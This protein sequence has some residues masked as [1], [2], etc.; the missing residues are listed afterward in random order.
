MSD[1]DYIEY[2]RRIEEMHLSPTGNFEAQ[3]AATIVNFVEGL[4]ATGHRPDRKWLERHLSD[5][6]ERD[7]G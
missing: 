6:S 7:P 3:M 5:I 2:L 1:D 4:E